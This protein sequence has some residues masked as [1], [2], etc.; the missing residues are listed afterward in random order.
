[1][2]TALL[3]HAFHRYNQ[4]V[5]RPRLQSG[6]CF[7]A[8][9]IVCALWASSCVAPLG[10]G[11]LVEKQEI[12]V[13]FLPAA[14]AIRIEADYQLRNTGVRA[15]REVEI[16]LPVERRLHIGAA[17]TKWDGAEIA[18]E[19]LKD[20][21]RNAMLRFAKPWPI[22][23][24]HTLHISYDILP[25]AADGAGLSFASDAFYLPAAGWSPQLPQLPGLFGF[26]GVPPKKW[27]LVIDVP[28]GFLVHSSGTLKK[29]SRDSKAN[30][31]TLRALQT[32]D[33]RYPFV[34]AARYTARQIHGTQQKINLWS[35]A[36]G[37]SGVLQQASAELA[38]T[39]DVYNSIFG[40]PASRA[41]TFWI[42]ECPVPEGCISPFR[43]SASLLHEDAHGEPSAELASSDTVMVDVSKGAPKLAAAAGPS[44]AASWLGYGRNPGF[45]EQTPPLSQLPIFAAARAREEIDGPQVRGETIRRA[46]RFIPK[47]AAATPSVDAAVN[48]ASPLGDVTNA[49]EASEPAVSDAAREARR[50][51]RAKSLLFFYA[52]QDRYGAKVFHDAINHMLY[53]RASRGF[54]LDDLIAAFEEEA[55]Q[56]VAAF[57]RLWM[58]HPGVPADFRARY[59]NSAVAAAP[60]GDALSPP[61]GLHFTGVTP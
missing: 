59:E 52:L 35:R 22:S 55:H 25:P 13:Q 61:S 3:L 19:P 49:S 54:E 53:A 9:L 12:R 27:E 45:Y 39:V 24:A 21:P 33:D 42:V 15:I 37:N 4:S 46:L 57:V 14:Q 41:K 43:P 16:L 23:E 40:I 56:N 8:L 50:I 47:N 10:P 18:T 5:L 11:Y 7:A 44:L 29:V 48:A 58:K 32:V 20:H 30:T 17:S 51:E 34:I 6:L 36:S 2:N 31:R 28:E 1:M 38:R 26:G 60:Q